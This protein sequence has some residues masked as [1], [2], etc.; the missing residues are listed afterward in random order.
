MNPFKKVEFRD[1]KVRTCIFCAVVC[2]TCLCVA[3]VKKISNV[4]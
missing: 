3:M 4:F 2:L 1:F